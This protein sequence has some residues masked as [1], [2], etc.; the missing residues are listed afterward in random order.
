RR[1]ESRDHRRSRYVRA[2]HPSL[3]EAAG[4]ACATLG[5]RERHQMRRTAASAVT[6]ARSHRAADVALIGGGI[7]GQFAALTLAAAG[8][9]VILMDRASLWAEASSVNA[10]SL[11]VQNKIPQLV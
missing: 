10:G 8:L 3:S 11:A 6:S 2:R 7:F 5:P 9:S 1:T 4:L